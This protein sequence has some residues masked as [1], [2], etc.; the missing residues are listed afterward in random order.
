VAQLARAQVDLYQVIVIYRP[1]WI[2]V[3]CQ[4]TAIA[5]ALSDL[6]ICLFAQFI[7]FL[8]VQLARA[9]A[10]RRRARQI[11]GVS[12]T[13]GSGVYALISRTNG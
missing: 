1:G 13:A 10:K 11:N 4:N 12:L 2:Q 6:L 7:L 5:N 8:L 9:L 3:W